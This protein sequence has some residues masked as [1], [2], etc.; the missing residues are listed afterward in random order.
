MRK[1]DCFNLA[2]LKARKLCFLQKIWHKKCI[3]YAQD[4]TNTPRL[5][6]LTAKNYKKWR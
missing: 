2:Y 1:N 4:T 3:F 6:Y 5:A